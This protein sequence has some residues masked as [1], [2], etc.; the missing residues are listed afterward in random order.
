MP[1]NFEELIRQY[2]TDEEK[3]KLA[4]EQRYQAALGQLDILGQAGKTRIG[5]QTARQQAAATQGLI[6]RGLGSTTITSAARRGIASDAEFQRQQLEESVAMQ[7]AGIMER[8]TDVGPDLGMFA[9]LL[10]MASQDRDSGQQTISGGLSAFASRGLTAFGQPFRYGGSGG[11]AGGDGTPDSGGD[12]GGGGGGIT[13]GPFGPQAT[14]L[15]TPWPERGVTPTF[16]GSNVFMGERG[17]VTSGPGTEGGKTVLVRHKRT[18]KQTIMDADAY[19]KL[20]PGHNYR[21]IRRN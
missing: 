15:A 3:S 10:Q 16:A 19:A 1:I 21:L 11:G 14:G 8:R 12:G 18:G 6:T 20:A 4:S 7:K 17:T 13:R 9:N 5:R 2:R